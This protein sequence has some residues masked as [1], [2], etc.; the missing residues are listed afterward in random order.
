[1]IHLRELVGDSA[2]A[3]ELAHQDKDRYHDQIRVDDHFG[4]L[5]AGHDDR[6][7]PTPDQTEADESDQQRCECQRNAG[8]AQ[9]DQNCET[10][11][12]SSHEWSSSAAEGG[13]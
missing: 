8:E 4:D 9:C 1:M 10:D 2:A 12:R 6:R 7:F 11:Q 5:L 13:R 3:N